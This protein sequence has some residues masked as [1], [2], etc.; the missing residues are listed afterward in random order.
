M[1][2]P[3][4][5]F[6]GP[7][8]TGTSWIHSALQS[9][10]DVRLPA[11]TKETFFF[12]RYYDKG[13]GWYD[14]QFDGGGEPALTVEVA[15]SYGGFAAAP[16]RLAKELPG[17][18]LVMSVRD[19]VERTISQYL[20]EI[21]Y[22]YY[23]GPIEPHLEPRDH[24]IRESCYGS[25]LSAWLECVPPQ[26]IAVIRYEGLREDPEAFT[27]AICAALGLP[28]SD[29]QLA[30]A[31]RYV[32]EAKEPRLAALSRVATA[33]ADALRAAGLHGLVAGAA[34]LGT[35]RLLERPVQAN[36]KRDLVARH[37]RRIRDLV[38]ADIR[39]FAR[40]LEAHPELSRYD[41]SVPGASWFG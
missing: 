37:G 22:G 36:A 16:A 5:V 19:P 34:R 41:R 30:L 3:D 38:E 18:R 27:R 2:L 11:R 7:L 23:T 28:A 33:G 13:V 32:N 31:D 10:V 35:R 15:P 1:P 4:V 39:L 25:I 21:R 24:I 17:A 9:R 6:I 29:G 12:D 14:G 8:K 26:S 20:H 40:L